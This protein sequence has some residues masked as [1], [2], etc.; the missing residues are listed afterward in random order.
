M[1]KVIKYLPALLIGSAVYATI[2]VC[3]AFYSIGIN[4]TKSLPE[5]VFLI[6]KGK[7]SF[8]RGD[9]IA[10]KIRDVAELDTPIVK[11]VA[12][13]EG[14]RISIKGKRFYINNQYVGTAKDKTLSGEKV[15]LTEEGIIPKGKYFV[16]ATHKDSLDSKYSKMGLISD[17]D[18]IGHA[19][20]IL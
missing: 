12:G 20:P 9:Y 13:K 2:S 4:E 14:D 3:S 11:I 19:F 16:Y 1:R 7:Q 15:T 10:F 6:K 18:A 8:D 5:K 17:S